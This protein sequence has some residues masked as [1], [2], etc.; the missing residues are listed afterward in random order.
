MCNTLASVFRSHG[1]HL[2][3]RFVYAVENDPKSRQFLEMSPEPP[4]MIFQ[5]MKDMK[6]DEAFDTISGTWKTIPRVD[7][8][9][10]GF[11][12]KGRSPMNIK[13]AVNHDCVEREEEG[14]GESFA[15]L[16]NWCLANKVAAVLCENVLNCA[17]TTQAGVSCFADAAN[18]CAAIGM[19]AI[20]PATVTYDMLCAMGR[21]LLS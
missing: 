2:H 11:L 20:R 17:T 5:D 18:A 16:R 1:V 4:P 10:A 15:W 6:G 13:A 3:F 7:L 14:T 12:C 21:S 9:I 19:R 8:G